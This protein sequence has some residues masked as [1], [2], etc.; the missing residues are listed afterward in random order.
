MKNQI[1]EMVKGFLTDN[2]IMTEKLRAQITKACERNSYLTSCYS[3]QVSEVQ[4]IKGKDSKTSGWYIVL[5]GCR[6]GVRFFINNDMEITRKPSKDK[7]EVKNSYSLFNY[8]DFHEGFWI[9][10]F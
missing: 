6:S 5:E 9:E 7:V 2:E 4:D 10:N 1:A 3:L 8:I